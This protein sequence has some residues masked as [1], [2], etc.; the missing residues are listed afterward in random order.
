MLVMQSFYDD[1]ING[2]LKQKNVIAIFNI[3][4]NSMSDMMV[5]S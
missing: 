4:S 1:M 3:V 5:K 2:E